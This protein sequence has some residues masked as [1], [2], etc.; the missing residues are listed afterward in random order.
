MAGVRLNWPPMVTV[1]GRL[2][3][4]Y[5]ALLEWV[6]RTHDVGERPPVILVFPI[7]AASISH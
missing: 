2:G 7:P 1:T 4:E 3:V 6:F 5:G